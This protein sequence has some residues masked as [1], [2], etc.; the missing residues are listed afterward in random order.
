MTAQVGTAK[1]DLGCG[2]GEERAECTG[3]D[4]LSAQ[5]GGDVVGDLGLR[6]GPPELDPADRLAVGASPD[7]Q[8][9]FPPP[10]Q[11]GGFPPPACRR[12]SGC[13]ASLRPGQPSSQ[14]S[15]RCRGRGRTGGARVRRPSAIDRA[16]ESRPRRSA[17]AHG[18]AN[19]RELPYRGRWPTSGH[20]TS[21]ELPGTKIVCHGLASA[22]MLRACLT[23]LSAGR[24]IRLRRAGSR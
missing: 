5:F 13:R 17:A 24:T 18:A 16:Q 22:S 3:C 11:A 8:V 4:A 9:Q 23:A 21:K 14:R 12:R 19:P 6:A 20:R 15:V 1:T 10:R 7:R 2:P